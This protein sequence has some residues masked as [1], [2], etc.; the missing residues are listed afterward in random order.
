MKDVSDTS[1]DSSSPTKPSVHDRRLKLSGRDVGFACNSNQLHLS[2]SGYFP[3]FLEKQKEGKGRAMPVSSNRSDTSKIV[4][5]ILLLFD[6]DIDTDIQD[7]SVMLSP[8]KTHSH[9]KSEVV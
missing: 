1:G 3:Q 6:I 9:S 8:T 7:C 5:D 2:Y 4:T